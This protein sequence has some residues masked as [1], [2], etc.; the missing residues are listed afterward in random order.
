[1]G[2]Q[3]IIFAFFTSFSAN[4]ERIPDAIGRQLVVF[5]LEV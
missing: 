2:E 5:I 1:V 4:H 3:G